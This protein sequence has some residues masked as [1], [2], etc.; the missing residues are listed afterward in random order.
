MNYPVLGLERDWATVR[1]STIRHSSFELPTIP[2]GWLLTALTLSGLAVLA[3]MVRDGLTVVA[4]SGGLAAFL[5]AFAVGGV[6][7]FWARSEATRLHER[8]KDFAEHSTIFLAISVLGGIASY[9]AATCTSGFADPMLSRCD[10]L[11]HFDWLAL[12][13]VVARNPLLQHAG[14]LAYSS[15]YISPFLIIG[16]HAWTGGRASARRFLLSFWLGATLTLLLFPLFPAK[17]ALEYLWR[18]PIPYMPTTGLYQGA[19]IP[20]LRAHALTSV[21]VGTMRGLVCAPS[22]HTVCG[23]LYMAAAWPVPALRRVL[24]PINLLMLTATPIEGAHYLSD[25]ILGLVVATVAIAMAHAAPGIV[26]RNRPLRL[27][28]LD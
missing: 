12:Y 10:H 26:G 24:V 2:R 8:V 11:L 19:I 9:A 21:D 16:Y 27:Q 1:R 23:V 7:W 5:A 22:F 25:M 17:G 13:R 4:A 6:A 18:G 20:A 3:L 15:I 14:A 28:P